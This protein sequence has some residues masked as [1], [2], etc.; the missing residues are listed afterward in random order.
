MDFI[1]TIY[2]LCYEKSESKWT[3]M[4]KI[5]VHVI[6]EFLNTMID[7]LLYIDEHKL[8]FTHK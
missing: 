1:S 4:E 5:D 2:K 8:I 3:F 7:G 6:E